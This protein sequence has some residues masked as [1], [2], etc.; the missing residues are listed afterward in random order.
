MAILD[1]DGVLYLMA[2]AAFVLGITAVI[3]CLSS[4]AA[5]RLARPFDVLTPQATALAHDPSEI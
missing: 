3:G 1:L 4:T 2:I 5:P